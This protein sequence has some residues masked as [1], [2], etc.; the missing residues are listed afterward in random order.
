MSWAYA[1][2]VFGDRPMPVRY[3]RN[4]DDRDDRHVVVPEHGPRSCP[5]AGD[6]HRMHEHRLLLEQ[7]HGQGRR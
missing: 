3:A 5:R 1:F 4:R 6:H 2:T 7:R